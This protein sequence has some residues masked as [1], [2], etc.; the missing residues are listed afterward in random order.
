MLVGNVPLC[1]DCE[2][3]YQQSRYM[4]FA[5]N[6]AMM[7]LAATEMGLSVGMP[8]LAAQIEIPR[9]PVPPIHY[10]NQ[11]VSVSGG[12]VGSI[13]FGPVETIKV[14][15]DVLTQAGAVGQAEALASVVNAVLDD[16]DLAVDKKNELLEQLAFVTKE[17][18]T[19][20]K[21]RKPSVLKSVLG[22]IKEGANAAGAIAS[23]WST[24][25]PIVRGYFGI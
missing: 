19:P 20:A 17:A 11:S 5:Q 13:N 24:A 6:A 12:N 21:D 7:N 14:D 15:I 10:N 23:A 18:A 25:E 8:D 22:T 16:S 9:A 2:Y 1:V 4:V 3:K